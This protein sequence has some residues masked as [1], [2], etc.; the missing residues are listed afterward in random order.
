MNIQSAVEEYLNWKGLTYPK[1]AKSYKTFLKSFV[2]FFGD[3][4]V[5]SIYL[6]QVSTFISIAKEKY[7][8]KSVYFIVSILK[9]FFKYYPNIVNPHHIKSPR[10]G[11]PDIHYVTE[12]EFELI[13]ASLSEWNVYELRAKLIHNILWSTGMRVGELCSIHLDDINLQERYAKIITE[14]SRRPGYVMWGE[15]THELL[16]RYLGTRLMNGGDYL[17]DISI[18]QVERI[19]KDVSEN[20]GIK[21][22]TPHKYRHGKSHKMLKDGATIDEISFTLRHSNPALTK[23]MYLRLDRDEN[24]SIMGKYV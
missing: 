16:L 23:Q 10:L 21:G 7:A 1:A 9:D 12:D 14:K 22:V 2:Q 18:R 20:I 6:Y 5:E 15:K 24:L 3:K 8:P 4:E 19:I 17:F 13:N 11:M